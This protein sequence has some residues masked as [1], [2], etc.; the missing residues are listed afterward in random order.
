MGA[1]CKAVLKAVRVA[2]VK[3]VA[4]AKARWRV[5]QDYRELKDELG[6]D[7]FEGRSWQGFHHHVALVTVAF[8]FLRQEQA[9]L[10]RRTKKSLPPPTLPQVRRSLQAAL[11]RL[12]GR[13]PRCRTRFHPPNFI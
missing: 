2:L 9:R 8:V 4:S 1:P 5:E 12:S 7:H 3:P 11:I 10:R 13:C 6:L